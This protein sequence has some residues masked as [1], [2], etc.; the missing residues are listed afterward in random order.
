[1]SAGNCDPQEDLVGVLLT[2]RAW[3]SPIPPNVCQDF[4]TSADQAIDD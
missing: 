2:Q 3:T 4:W 1:M